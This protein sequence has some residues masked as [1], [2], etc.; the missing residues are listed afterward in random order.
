MAWLGGDSSSDGSGRRVGGRL[1]RE[2]GQTRWRLPVNSQILRV[3][4]YRFRATFGRRWGGYL[5]IVLL[6][7]LVGGLA[8][9]SIAGARRTQASFPFYLASTNPS[10]LYLTTANWAPGSPNVAGTDLGTAGSL[11]RLHDVR[12]VENEYSIDAQPLGP[13]GFP[14][15]APAKAVSLGVSVLNNDGSIDGEFSDQDRLT[16]IAGRLA[17]PQVADEIVV[18]PTVA[19]G[20]SLHVGEVVPIG[21]YTNAQTNLP[22]Y[23]TGSATFTTKPHLRLDMRVVGIVAF[24]NQVVVDSLEVTETAQIVYTPALTR[25]LLNCCISNTVSYLQLDHGTADIATVEGEIRQFAGK[26]GPPPFGVESSTAVAERAIKPESIALGAFGGIA[27]L[28]ALLIAGQA[29]GRQL[30]VGA[31]EAST[32][33]ALGANPAMTMGDGLA[34]IVIATVIGSLFAVVVAIGLSPLTPFGVVRPVYPAAGVAFDW[35]VLGLGFVVLVLAL[36][37]LS[38]VIA[39]REAPHRIGSQGDGGFRRQS[40]VLRA[41]GG[42]ALPTPAVE[43]IR[44]ALDPG[45]G[46]NSVPVRSAIVGT[47]L[48]IVV[49]IATVTF[50]VSLDTLV[51]RPALYG[52]NWNYELTGG[53]GI[54]PVPG[55][56]AASLLGHDRSVAAWS[57][58]IF[59]GTASVEGQEIPVIGQRAYAAVSP[60]VLSGHGLE[61]SNQVVLGGATLSALHERIGDTIKVGIAGETTRLLI[62]GT[63]TMPTIGEQLGGLHPT[64]GT[65]ALVSSTLIPASL[66]NP[67]GVEPTG[68]S[69]L[70][71]RLQSRADPA[72]SLRALNR[73]A[74]ELTLP[75]NY[76]VSVLPVQRPAEIINYRSMGTIPVYLGAGLGGGAVAA[77]ALTLVASVR[78]RRRDLALLKTL[79]FTGRQLAATVAWQSSVAVGIGTV[80]GVPLGIVLGRS[81]WDVFAHEI[82]AVPVPSVPVLTIAVIAVGALVLANLVAA[83]P[84][85][86]A[87]RTPTALLLRAE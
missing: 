48:A 84:A 3:A 23:G 21:F 86:I 61:A 83:I 80:V 53:G 11:A 46:R 72:L 52:W 75:S 4:R 12:R 31:D 34:G 37:A 40:T 69:A 65:G 2:R 45:L 43:G 26:G 15:H 51:S 27:A 38:V 68:P 9:A 54:A 82:N 22:G 41:V 49:V 71:V 36:S 74:K 35:P 87:A 39:F 5:T 13:S 20:L 7:G 76:G 70:L 60:P 50:G 28:A 77:L 33:R 59:G 78:R 47:T 25:R 1:G 55:S 10:D 8:M 85:R 16:P 18:S 56:Q 42:S 79:R 14:M 67:N 19:E 64:M 57:G 29:I 32:L 63:A 6:V 44:F 62:V 73:I 17:N 66:S 30:H 81:L 24:N 58:V